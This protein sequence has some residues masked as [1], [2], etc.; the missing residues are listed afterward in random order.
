MA[1]E[2]GKDGIIMEKQ[3]KGKEKEK[4]KEKGKEKLPRKIVFYVEGS[5]AIQAITTFIPD[6][7]RKEFLSIL[8]H[9]TFKHLNLPQKLAMTFQIYS[10]HLWQT[11]DGFHYHMPQKTSIFQV[12]L[13]NVRFFVC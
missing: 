10:Q 12:L 6:D 8:R 7:I 13:K 2:L 11:V 1:P 9:P 4:E 3:E 5:E